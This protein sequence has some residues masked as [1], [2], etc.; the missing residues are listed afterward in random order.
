MVLRFVVRRWKDVARYWVR[1]AQPALLV[2]LV[3]F[4]REA[5]D[6]QV[7]GPVKAFFDNLSW[8]SGCAAATYLAHRLHKDK[9]LED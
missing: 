9:P 8:L 5:F 7:H 3:V 6:G 4:F 1:L 2:L